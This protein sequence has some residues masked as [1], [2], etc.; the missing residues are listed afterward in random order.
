MKTD[1]ELNLPGEPDPLNQRQVV[2]LSLKQD[3]KL[4]ALC[5]KK[6]LSVSTVGRE[7]LQAVDAKTRG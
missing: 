4:R 2:V 7:T 1:V 3:R 5:K 6:G